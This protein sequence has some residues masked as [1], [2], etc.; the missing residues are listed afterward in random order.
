MKEPDTIRRLI[1]RVEKPSRYLGTEVNSIDKKGQNIRLKIALAFPD[2][3]E[4]G[5]SHFGLQILYHILNSYEDIAAERVFAPGADMANHLKS[6]RTPLFSLETKTPISDF[7]ILG[8]SLLYELNYT[9]IL[10]M[11]ELAGLPFYASERNADAPLVIAGGPC[12]CN[13]EPVSDFFDAIVIGDGENVILDIA[14]TYLEWK[15]GSHRDKRQLLSRLS[16]IDGVYIPSFFTPEYDAA[17]FQIL[18]PMVPDYT[19]IRRNILTDLDTAPFPNRPIIPYGKP[20]HDRLRLEIARGCTR[21]CRFC[22]AGMIYRPVRERSV[23]TL[24]QLA[25]AGLSSTGYEDLSLLSLSTGDY[26]GIVE[27][28]VRLMHRC[29]PERTAISFPS[30]RAGTLSPELMRLIRKV[31]K[32][33]FTIA[34][35][36]GSQRLRDVINKN[37]DEK[38]IIDTVDDAFKLGWQLIKLYF[39]V[40]LPTETDADI[41]AIIDLITTLKKSKS[42]KN[43]KKRFNV[44]VATF[45]PKPHTPF[46]WFAMNTL[47]EARDKIEKVKFSLG[48][49]G[50]QFKWQNP[51]V[52]MMEGLWARGDRRLSRLLVRA[53]RNGCIFD[54]WTDHFDFGKWREAIETENIDADFFTNRER[55]P[56]EPLPWDHIRIGVDTSF[57][58]QEWENALTAQTI[59]DCRTEACNDCGVC[60][61]EKIQPI[62]ARSGESVDTLPGSR[63]DRPESAPDIHQIMKATY[64]KRGN[65][66]FFGHLEMANIILRA[67]RRVRIPVRYSQGYHPMPK[68]SFSDPIP[69]GLESIEETFFMELTEKAL[70]EVIV[71]RLNKNLPDGLHILDCREVRSKKMNADDF[72]YLISLP[73]SFTDSRQL[74]DFEKASAFIYKRTN[75]KGKIQTL[76]LKQLISRIEWI[77]PN[78]LKMVIKNEPGQRVRPT[79]ILEHVFKCSEEMIQR[80]DIVKFPKAVY[81]SIQLDMD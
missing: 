26:T 55:S 54:G 4:I 69:V 71:E 53:Y 7:D 77:S 5:T 38:D 2:L 81:D 14:H 16:K 39:M 36:A 9:N 76:D 60:D 15:D 43:R 63:M 11:L 47:S 80:T 56:D 40:G 46:Q 20:V 74:S 33:G 42:G 66:K 51:E 35:E 31:R 75:N 3:Y 48:G 44:S 28:M 73:P 64:S 30:L 61:F 29:E 57:L 45:I 68:V 72:G 1:S 50:I 79:E 24:T 22:Q 8:F 23:D 59:A 32:T 78:T 25:D 13:P 21:G 18:K 17:G 6:N 27:L 52:S 37:I 34:P 65:A 58:I 67:I 12:M 10:L 19:E 49:S 70:P 41:D 62:T